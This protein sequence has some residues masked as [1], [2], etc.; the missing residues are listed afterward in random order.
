MAF[1]MKSE[2]VLSIVLFFNKCHTLS[3]VYVFPVAVFRVVSIFSIFSFVAFRSSFELWI[4]MA[5]YA[6]AC[7]NSLFLAHVGLLCWPGG[8]R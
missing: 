6:S 5:R 4:L 3:G 8:S 1:Q 7:V 2:V